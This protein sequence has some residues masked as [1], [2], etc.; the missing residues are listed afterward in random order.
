MKK[1]LYAIKRRHST[2]L[3]ELIPLKNIKKDFEIINAI[4]KI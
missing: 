3:L 1:K 4:R 2:N